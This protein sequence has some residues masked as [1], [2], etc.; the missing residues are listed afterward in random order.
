MAETRATA[1]PRGGDRSDGDGRR[2][3]GERRGKATEE[4]REERSRRGR[5]DWRWLESTEALQREAFGHD[6][7]AIGRS[8][9]LVAATLRDNLFA[10]AVELLGETPRE[11][12]WKYWARDKPWVNRERVLE[13]L[14]DVGH[15]VANMLVALD[16]DDDEWESAYQRKQDENRRRQLDG[17]TVKGKR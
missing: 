11:F 1:P 2:G 6:W 14:V 13:E 16:V 10:A 3:G 12:A 15:F 7:S 5:S 9:A 17:Y 8:P 4:A